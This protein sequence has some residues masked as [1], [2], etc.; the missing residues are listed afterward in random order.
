M[1]LRGPEHRAQ[2]DMHRAR[3]LDARE[4]DQPVLLEGRGHRLSNFRIL[5][6][7]TCDAFDP[8]TEGKILPQGAYIECGHVNAPGPRRS[9]RRAHVV[10]DGSAFCAEGKVADRSGRTK[11]AH[12]LQEQVMIDCLQYPSRWL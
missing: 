10:I 11:C 7:H 2:R 5:H 3:W 6:I 9:S 12:D 8:D 1:I 4:H